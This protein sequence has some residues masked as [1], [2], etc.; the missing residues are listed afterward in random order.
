MFVGD[1]QG[2]VEVRE[3]GRGEARVA[4][5]GDATERKCRPTAR[6]RGIEPNVRGSGEAQPQLGNPALDYLASWN[7]LRRMVVLE[8]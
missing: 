5:G 3:V 6:E 1:E 2:T 7:H 8:W 4:D